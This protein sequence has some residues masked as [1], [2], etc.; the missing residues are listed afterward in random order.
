MIR[1]GY[2]GTVHHSANGVAAGIAY[3]APFASNPKTRRYMCG[4]EPPNYPVPAIRQGFEFGRELGDEDRGIKAG[5]V[6]L[7]WKQGPYS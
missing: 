7:Y 5:V 4:L 1:P 6:L 2:L 3:I